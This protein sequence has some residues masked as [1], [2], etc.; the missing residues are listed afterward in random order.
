MGIFNFG[1]DLK[2]ENKDLKTINKQ[3]RT[4]NDKFEEKYEEQELRHSDRL[5]DIERKQLLRDRY[6]EESHEDALHRLSQ[7]HETEIK[8]IQDEADAQ[9]EDAQDEA[10]AE[11]ES[12]QKSFDA[13][14]KK[15]ETTVATL[16]SKIR[17]LELQVKEKGEDARIAARTASLDAREEAGDEI[18]DLQVKLATSQ[19]AVA[20]AKAEGNAKDIVIKALEKQLGTSE[21]RTNTQFETLVEKLPDVALD[22]FLMN[23]EVPVTVTQKDNGQQKKQ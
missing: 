2:E 18:R 19:A 10:D 4:A 11:I 7:A 16:E 22:K 14:T 8:E 5:H 12:A 3:L 6:T 21:D 13:E 17:T 9:V 1:S 15:L 23:I 20:T